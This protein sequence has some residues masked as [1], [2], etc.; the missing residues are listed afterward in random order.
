MHFC[1]QLC[2]PSLT[3][4]LHFACVQCQGDPSDHSAWTMT[5]QQAFGTAPSSDDAPLPPFPRCPVKGHVF[6]LSPRCPECG[7]RIFPDPPLGIWAPSNAG[8]TVFCT[9][10]FHEIE[11]SFYHQTGISKEVAVEASK[12]RDE[13]GSP[14]STDGILPSK[15]APGDHSTMIYQFTKDIKKPKDRVVLTD[16][17]GEDISNLLA[18]PGGDLD[19][20]A[21]QL[22]VLWPQKTMI[23][24][25][26]D[27]ESW[28]PEKYSS[29]NFPIQKKILEAL[30]EDRI[31]DTPWEEEDLQAFMDATLDHLVCNGE[32]VLTPI[33]VKNFS[34]FVHLAEQLLQTNERLVQ[35][36]ADGG[37][38]LVTILAKKLQDLADALQR[39]NH[40]AMRIQLEQLIQFMRQNPMSGQGDT[41]DAPMDKKIAIVVSKSDTLG[42]SCPDYSDI[43]KKHNLPLIRGEDNPETPGFLARITGRN[44]PKGSLERWQEAL[45]EMSNRSRKTLEEE[46]ELQE[47]VSRLEDNFEEVGYFFVSSTGRGTR[48][49]VE[50]NEVVHG[51]MFQG[52]SSAMGGVGAVENF[53][54]APVPRSNDWKAFEQILPDRGNSPIPQ[55][56]NVIHPL[57]WL[58]LSEGD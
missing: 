29:L 27:A 34:A 41:P 44:R 22:R 2:S 43:L 54:S 17:A 9:A 16:M 33:P 24:V 26:P 8:K 48:I 42:K 47:L 3:Q 40:Q 50:S 39:P 25:D 56:K 5:Y 31:L 14:F 19:L 10:L 52:K 55:P 15:T 28:G 4:D 37:N 35:R 11:N 57:L 30:K 21:A 38:T 20:L 58:L 13:V 36:M 12:Y 46:F 53:Q 45:Q 7:S 32:S 51:G 18:N 23:L 6:D 49:K 1:D